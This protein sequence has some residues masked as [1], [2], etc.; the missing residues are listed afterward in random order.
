MYIC[1]YMI[2]ML[3]FPDQLIE[4]EWKWKLYCCQVLILQILFF[5]FAI[6]QR[7]VNIALGSDIKLSL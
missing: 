4:W 6:F 1:I 5:H 2:D 7:F 3:M